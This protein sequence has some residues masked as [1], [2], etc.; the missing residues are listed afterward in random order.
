M[1][2]L[3]IVFFLFSLSLWGEDFMIKKAGNLK[4]ILNAKGDAW[5]E[6]KEDQGL[7]ERYLAPWQGG[8]PARGGGFDLK[9]L[10]VFKELVV[11]NRVQLDWFWDGHLRVL[12][13]NK[14]KPFNKSG[15]LNGTLIQKGDKWIDVE[16][17]KSFVPW[18]FYAKWVGGMPEAG[19]SYNP[20][21]L[22]F[23][24]KFNVNEPVRI[25]WSYDH[26]PRI[27]RF[28]E[29]EIED[30]FVP[31][32][33]GKTIP[34]GETNSQTDKTKLKPFDQ[35][36]STNPFDHAVPSIPSSP[37]DQTPRSVNA[38]P[39]DS[40]NQTSS[41]PFEGG[42]KDKQKTNSPPSG[43]PFDS[44]PKVNR[45]EANPFENVPLPGNPFDTVPEN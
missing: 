33:E 29:Q 36:P 32:Y 42:N 39:F 38:N 9:T 14:I 1:K 37:F 3:P 31:F 22:A 40:V 6:V 17:E 4:G 44:A 5:I 15:F 18:R 21:T 11:G 20:T 45:K 16:S 25:V 12:K 13:V 7:L 8:S 28:I 41:N 35:V 10:D 23:F 30:V 19:G 24:D 43:N 26:R 2:F 27:E 34:I